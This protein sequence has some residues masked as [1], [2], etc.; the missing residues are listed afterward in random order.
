MT[1]FF[2][3]CVLK[4]ASWSMHAIYIP[5]SYDIISHADYI[6]INEIKYQ[7]LHIFL[8][9]IN[10]DINWHILLLW[11]LLEAVLRAPNFRYQKT[12]THKSLIDKILHNNW[13]CRQRESL[14]STHLL[15]CML[16]FSIVSCNLC[17]LHIETVFRSLRLGECYRNKITRSMSLTPCR[18]SSRKTSYSPFC[19]HFI[20]SKEIK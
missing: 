3:L 4:C 17:T 7:Y 2:Y 8:S 11:L 12:N 15:H 6:F 20:Y 13:L 19:A 1:L 10:N 16:H 14:I 5:I 9:V 18:I